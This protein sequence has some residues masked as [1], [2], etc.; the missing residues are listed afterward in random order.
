MNCAKFWYSCI[1]YIIII[2]TITPAISA[3]DDWLLLH[4]GKG[5]DSDVYYKKDSIKKIDDNISEA[6]IYWC[7]TPSKCALQQIRIDCRNKKIAIGVSDIYI[8]R[9]KTQSYDF[10]KAGWIWAL[11][12]NNVDKKLLKL[13]CKKK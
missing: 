12:K 10:S 4:R 6:R 11:P 1:F 2:F 3:E 5:S 13:V 9:D 8:N 7:N